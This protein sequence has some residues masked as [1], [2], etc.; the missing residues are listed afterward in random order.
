MRRSSIVD[1]LQKIIQSHSIARSEIKA[2]NSPGT[3]K[4]HTAKKCIYDF[5]K[6]CNPL[7]EPFDICKSCPFGYLYCIG[8]LVRN[9]YQ[10][11]IGM[12]INILGS[13]SGQGPSLK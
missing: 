7:E 11:V 2:G 4:A 13:G 8:G 10:K 3:K 12:A 6:D 9:F 1:E 5:L